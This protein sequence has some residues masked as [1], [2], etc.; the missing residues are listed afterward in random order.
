[1][2]SNLSKKIEASPDCQTEVVIRQWLVVFGGL[3]Q[4]ELTELLIGTYCEA[5]SDLT[6]TEIALGCKGAIKRL[7]FFPTPAEIR[8]CLGI[9]RANSKPELRPRLPVWEP[10][11]P[12]DLV[13]REEA[14]DKIR[15]LAG[16]NISG[17]P[18][19]TYTLCP[20]HSPEKSAFLTEGQEALAKHRP[21]VIAATEKTVAQFMERFLP[22]KKP[23]AET[24]GSTGMERGPAVSPRSGLIQ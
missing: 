10:E 13:A 14:L 12:E 24:D 22:G 19:L 8:E 18:V 1:M 11:T 17:E 23:V 15:E 2:P 4:R 5:L 21:E 16:K 3:F 6:P 9:A 20:K 7:K